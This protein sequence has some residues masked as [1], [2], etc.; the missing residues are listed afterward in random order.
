MTDYDLI[1]KHGA[2]NVR[3]QAS[4]SHSQKEKTPLMRG[5]C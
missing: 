3:F 1:V 5:S 4:T 2:K